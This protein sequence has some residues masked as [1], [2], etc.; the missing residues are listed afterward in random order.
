MKRATRMA[1]V[2]GEMSDCM[3][4]GRAGGRGARGGAGRGA[5]DPRARPEPRAGPAPHPQCSVPGTGARARPALTGPCGRGAW[6]AARGARAAGGRGRR[7]W[8]RT[9]AR[10][11][12]EQAARPA[13]PRKLGR[14]RHGGRAVTGG[15]PAPRGA[16]RSRPRATGGA[17]RGRGFGAAGWGAEGTPSADWAGEGAERGTA[18]PLRPPR[19]PSRLSA[20]LAPRAVPAL[21]VSSSLSRMPSSPPTAQC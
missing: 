16:A 2:T 11:G 14:R 15:S 19:D 1:L 9:R 3:A 17:G 21:D 10:A 12:S 4:P 6:R 13:S 8:A 20:L 7:P 18:R 5:H